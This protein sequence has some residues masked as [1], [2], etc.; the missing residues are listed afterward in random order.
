MAKSVVVA[1]PERA[2]ECQAGNSPPDTGA[3]PSKPVG[4]VIDRAYRRFAITWIG[5]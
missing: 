4:A 2:N 3:C 1:G 5:S